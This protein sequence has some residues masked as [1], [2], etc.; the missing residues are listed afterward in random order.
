MPGLQQTVHHMA[1]QL[2]KR[3]AYTTGTVEMGLQVGGTLTETHAQGKTR[4]ADG[5]Q[6]ARS[7]QR[8]E[9][10]GAVITQVFETNI[11]VSVRPCQAGTHSCSVC[12]IDVVKYEGLVAQRH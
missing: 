2:W 3:P 11:H 12:K 8:H 7:E 4:L 1:C 5:D 10:L 6:R 9:L